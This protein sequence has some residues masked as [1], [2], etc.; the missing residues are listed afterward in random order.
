MRRSRTSVIVIA[1]IL[2][3]ALLAGCGGQKTTARATPLPD[4]YPIWFL[5]APSTG[6]QDCAVG[7]ARTYR[8]LETSRQEA[9]ANA[10]LNLA[11]GLRVHISGEHAFESVPRGKAYRGSN[12]REHVDPQLVES[13]SD[14]VV[15]AE[16]ILTNGMM[17]TLAS[18]AELELPAET[19]LPTSPPD[20]LETLP[21]SPDYDYAV[22]SCVSY[23]YALNSW[24]EAERQ[25]RIQL[26]L[27]RLSLLR[28]LSETADRHTHEVTVEG[29]NAVLERVQIVGRYHDFRERAYYVLARCRRAAEPGD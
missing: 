29:T 4:P 21:S 22:G 24:Q 19:M 16:P 14:Q 17:I 1:P 23:Y 3:S 15:Y 20:W 7:Y 6:T 2:A 28:K 10:L 13:L 8:N 26:A 18:T 27:S 9:E 12:I 5:E 11:K 25:A